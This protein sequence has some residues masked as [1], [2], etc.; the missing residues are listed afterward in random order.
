MNTS[1]AAGN[2]MCDFGLRNNPFNRMTD[3]FFKPFATRFRFDFHWND[4]AVFINNVGNDPGNCSDGIFRRPRPR[5]FAGADGDAFSS[6]D[7][8]KDFAPRNK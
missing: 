3:L 6:F 5:R 1:F 4:F 8:R 2:L 7:Q